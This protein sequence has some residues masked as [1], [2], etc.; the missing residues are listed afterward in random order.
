[1]KV[2]VLIPGVLRAA[3]DGAA[4]LDVEVP[5]PATLGAALD[6]LADT[7]PL[8]DRRLRDERAALRRYVNFYVNGEECRRLGGPAT[9]LPSGA[10]IQ[11]LP[12]VA[13]G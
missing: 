2:K 5:D 1:M 7:Y 13:G 3:T 6:V 4:H 9:P 11:I 12:S 8:L 10:E